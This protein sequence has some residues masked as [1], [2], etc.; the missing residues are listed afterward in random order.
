MENKTKRRVTVTSAR[1]GNISIIEPQYGI[2][3]TWHNK[4][5]QLQID[6]DKLEEAMYHPGVNAMFTE[7]Y[8]YIENMQDKID[9]G[10]E[11]ASAESP[12]KIIILNEDQVKEALSSMS[13]DEMK[14]LFSTL[15][16]GQVE[17][18]C[19][20]AIERQIMPSIAKNTYFKKRV[21]VDVIQAIQFNVELEE[22]EKAGK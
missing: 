5:A 20:F 9:L 15:P 11:P 16:N 8:L 13:F 19:A 21:N 2:N 3:R 10:L 17:D 14:E 22:A 12:E 1:R 6:F 18:I 7:G 4:G